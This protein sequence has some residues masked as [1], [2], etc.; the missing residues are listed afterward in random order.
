MTIGLDRKG[1]LLLYRRALL[2]QSGAALS[3]SQKKPAP[4]F[5]TG[6]AFEVLVASD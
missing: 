4:R 6:R 5:G 1:G 2:L 3:V